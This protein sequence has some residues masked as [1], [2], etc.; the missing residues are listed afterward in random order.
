MPVRRRTQ[1]QQPEPES[2]VPGWVW[3]IVIVAVIIIAKIAIRSAG[4]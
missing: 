1:R 4:R 3:T 2:G